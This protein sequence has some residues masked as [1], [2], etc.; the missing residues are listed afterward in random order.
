[1]PSMDG[2]ERRDGMADIK[3]SI[4]LINQTLERN[5]RLTEQIYSV[6]HG[7]GGEGLLTTVAKVKQTLNSH[8][9]SILRIWKTLSSVIGGTGAIA[10]ILKIFGVI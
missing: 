5:T 10:I 3:T 1:M 9:K 2:V 8:D 7:N 4:A 6:L